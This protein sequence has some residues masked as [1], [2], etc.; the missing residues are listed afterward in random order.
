M[1]AANWRPVQSELNT[2]TLWYITFFLLMYAAQSG[3]G[4]PAS[5][6]AFTVESI[7]GEKDFETESAG[8]FR[9]ADE[10]HAYWVWE[11][12]TEPQGGKDLWLK[13]P[14]SGSTEMVVCAR[15]L[16]PDGAENPL[17]AAEY[18]WSSN[19]RYLLIFTNTKR[20]WRQNTRGDYWVLDKERGLLRK[21]GGKAE[22]SSLMFA[23]FSPDGT[24]VAYVRE[25]NLYV[26]HLHNWRI[27]QLT[28]D[29]G[30]LLV[31]G[32]S[33]WVN[34]EELGLR[35]AYKWSPDG[36]WLLYWQFNTADVAEY[37]LV[38]L[39]DSLYPEVTSFPY[40]KVGQTNSAC[41]LGLDKAS[42]GRTRWLET[43][44]DPRNRY[45]PDAAWLPDS[46]GVVFQE[47]NRLQNTNRLWKAGLRAGKS[48]LVFEDTDAAW[49]EHQPAWHWVED[50]TS[51]LW[52]SEK[53]GWS[54][55][56]RVELESGQAEALTPK[57][58]DVVNLVGVSKSKREVLVVASPENPTQRFLYRVSLVP[59][60]DP[61]RVTPEEPRGIHSYQVSSDMQWGLH[62]Y[63]SFGQPPVTELVT[64]PEHESA[65]VLADNSALREKLQSLSRIEEELFRI[66]IGNGVEL[67]AWS[68]RTAD[69]DLSKRHP[70]LVHVY[71]EP[72]GQTVLDRWGGSNYLWHRMLAE[73][74]IVVVSIDNRGTPAP[75]GRE[76]RKCVYGQVGVLAS[77]DQAAAVQKLLA[78]RPYLDPERVGVWGWS[79]GGSM[80]LNAM[81]RY[82]ELYKVG[83]SVAFVAN[84]LF[85]DTIY[86]E[87]YMGLP[88]TNAEGYRHGSPITHAG[89]L[90]GELLLIY[91]TGDD[92]CHYQNCES[93]VNELVR[94]GK[95]FSMLSYPNRTHSIREGE[96]TR[97]HL[98]QSM[99]RFLQQNLMNR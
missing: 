47:L 49:V 52:L 56:Y 4:T 50:G 74:G 58:F 68:I 71:G 93:L 69:L 94:L 96:G 16:I 70:L 14:D 26:Q 22:E 28:K 10:G 84:Q 83:V 67:D 54:T 86:Q 85:Y 15:E 98:Y 88:D 32:T 42:G 31:N 36:N 78:D 8:S 82:P 35:K 76:W 89:G 20:V 95:P 65:K 19:R 45:L 97:V 60:R 5:A 44:A 11:D 6:P 24:R 13:H 63:S 30:G 92:N 18:A 79:G 41:R 9:W 72:A 77:A 81:F 73:Q 90:Q 64:L 39:T 34:E 51:F 75:R 33:D 91:G 57:G 23:S 59:G 27:Q 25:K 80:T 43:G 87:R 38:N 48:D 46:T 99:T 2:K 29:G 61:I 21:L 37:R 40:P 12:S 66:D 55:L 3:E 1:H 7:F 17:E 53:S 62:T